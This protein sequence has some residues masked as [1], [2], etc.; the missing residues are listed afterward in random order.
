[1]ASMLDSVLRGTQGGFNIAND[2]INANRADKTYKEAEQFRLGQRDSGI[3]AVEKMRTERPDVKQED[4]MQ[5][6]ADAQAMHALQS[7]RNDEFMK[8]FTAGANMREFQR[9]R[10]LEQA[11]KVFATTG[12]YNSY[13]GAYNSLRDGI[14]IKAIQPIAPPSVGQDGKPVPGKFKVQFS[15]GGAES[16]RELDENGLKSVLNV[17]RDPAS[18]RRIE[19]E[20]FAAERK[21]RID[22]DTDT[23]KTNNEIA[24]TILTRD[25]LYK[26]GK[27][28]TLI[29]ARTGLPVAQGSGSSSTATDKDQRGFD[30][31]IDDVARG[32]YGGELLP[33]MTSRPHSEESVKVSEIATRIRR[34]GAQISAQSAVRVAREGKPAMATVRLPNGQQAQV[35]AVQ[36]EGKTYLLGDVGAPSAAPP[37]AQPPVPAQPQAS[38]ETAPSVPRPAP[39]SP[40][41]FPRVSPQEQSARDGDR[42][43][44]LNE[45]LATA[46][47]QLQAA[48]QSGNPDAIAQHQETVAALM[49]EISRTQTPTTPAQVAAAGGGG[50]LPALNNKERAAVVRRL[51]ELEAVRSSMRGQNTAEIDQAIMRHK[52]ALGGAVGQVVRR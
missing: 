37:N 2:V 15:R 18:A 46:G 14:E 3:Q 42:L 51:S 28:D 26:V 6:M 45:E 29:D 47:Q 19:L 41:N 32:S 21:G 43:A 7:G 50:A 12:D 48:R 23:A 52:Q 16:E 10:A 33:G 9:G 44:I 22:R 30:S 24:K 27:D 31:D 17:L 38:R 40:A 4:L 5:A 39:A 49:R 20:T 1:M 25:P 34:G 8:H 13:I 36:H 35:P 11:D